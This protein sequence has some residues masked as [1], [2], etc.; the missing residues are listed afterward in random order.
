M[1]TK[2]FLYME[3]MFSFREIFLLG[4]DFML[5]YPYFCQ[6]RPGSDNCGCQNLTD[7]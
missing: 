6:S 7:V 1:R 2:I 5:E 3:L 4:V